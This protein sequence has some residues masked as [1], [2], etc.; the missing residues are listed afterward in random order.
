MAYPE[1]KTQPRKFTP[2]P[3]D[4]VDSRETINYS[5]SLKSEPVRN[6]VVP[7]IS[8]LVA[9]DTAKGAGFG[10]ELQPG[11]PVAALRTVTVGDPAF[12]AQTSLSWVLVWADSKADIKGPPG[13][14]KA[15]KARKAAQTT[16][17]FV[18]VVDA[19]TAQIHDT[20]QI[21]RSK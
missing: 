16:C 8:K 5:A 13:L 1:H 19:T 10:E 18:V 20:R 11:Q 6:K 21:C 15:E 17:V 7:N 9:I 12:G 4:D 2:S 3:L 14:D